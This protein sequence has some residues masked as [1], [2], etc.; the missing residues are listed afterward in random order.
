MTLPEGLG[1]DY[2]KVIIISGLI[3]KGCNDYR[4]I[5]SI[6]KNSEGVTLTFNKSLKTLW[7]L[8]FYNPVSLSGLIPKSVKYVLVIGLVFFYNPVSLSGLIPKG[9]NDY[10]K[11]I[12]ISENSEGVTLTL[13]KSLTKGHCPKSPKGNVI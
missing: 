1:N 9:C 6:S 11:V 4:K 2:T 5:I 10:R 7:S 13:N 12:R 8:G 3:P